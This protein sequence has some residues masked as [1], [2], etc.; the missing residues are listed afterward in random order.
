G[1]WG[2]WEVLAHFLYW[3]ESTARGMESVISGAGPFTVAVETDAMNA[4]SIERHLAD[5][6]GREA[7]CAAPVGSDGST[8]TNDVLR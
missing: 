5:R 7:H 3:H 8:G 2:S 1:D 6:S 4:E